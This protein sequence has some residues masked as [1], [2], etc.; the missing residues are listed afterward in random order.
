M[1]SLEG[2]PPEESLQKGNMSMSQTAP[3]T[4][5][6]SEENSANFID[7]AEIFVPGR[8]EQTATLLDLIPA[9]RD[10][11]FT[12]V[13][14]ASGEGVLA[15]AVMEGF[16]RC[17]YVALDRSPLMR[18]RTKQRVERFGDRLEV[19]PRSEERRV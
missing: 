15:E 17:H 11:A 16:P 9:E 5:Q 14:L 10:E 1:H 19:Q 3:A 2:S 6:W 8:V 12:I 18:E 13:E 4:N 7:L